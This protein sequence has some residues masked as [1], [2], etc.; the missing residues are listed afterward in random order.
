LNGNGRKMWWQE[1]PLEAY[2]GLG[3]QGEAPEAQREQ[4]PPI[5]LARAVFV[6]RAV[7][8]QACHKP[9]VA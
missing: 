4:D 2:E 5:Q 1:A 6:R 9:E 7:A 8:I 3:R